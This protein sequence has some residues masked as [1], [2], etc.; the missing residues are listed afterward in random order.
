MGK[1]ENLTDIVSVDPVSEIYFHAR[2]NVA[3]IL[4]RLAVRNPKEVSLLEVHNQF[5]R[6][7]KLAE[8]HGLLG[9]LIEIWILRALM[10]HV[11]GKTQEAHHILQAAL[12]AAA[13]RG[14][15]R[16]FL[17]ESDLIRA[18]LQALEN[19]LKDNELCSYVRRLLDAMPGGS[20][21]DKASIEDEQT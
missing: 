3:H 6:H 7:E 12:S 14:Y 4:T 13:P 10:Y 21:R 16:I 18:L 11:E 2:L 5:A 19:G 15:F 20:A 8:A 17:D 9:W 1:F